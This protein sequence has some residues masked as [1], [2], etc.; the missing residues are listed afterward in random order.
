MAEDIN[1]PNWATRLAKDRINFVM[2]LNTALA[3]CTSRVAQVIDDAEAVG[4]IFAT[5]RFDPFKGH[6]EEEPVEPLATARAELETDIYVLAGLLLAGAYSAV[7]DFVRALVATRFQH[8]PS[9]NRLPGVCALRIRTDL[10]I[11]EAVDKAWR[12]AAQGKRGLS[13]FEALLSPFGYGGV[14]DPGDDDL[15]AELEEIRNKFDHTI[16]SADDR[17]LTRVAGTPFSVGDLIKVPKDRFE[18]YMDVVHAYLYEILERLRTVDG[19]PR[20]F[21]ADPVASRNHDIWR[22]KEMSDSRVSKNA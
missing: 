4:A 19:L 7:E 15:M 12:L 6:V 11:D 8:D 2:R 5:S 20:A 9:V 13:R 14:T 1:D 17:F 21:G 18:E 3:L 16:G 22:P 10:P